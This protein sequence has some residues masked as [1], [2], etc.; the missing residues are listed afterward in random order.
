MDC[1]S[2][3]TLS[4]FFLVTEV[5]GTLN[6]G[7]ND[8]LLGLAPTQ[9]K[10]FKSYLDILKDQG[11]IAR[12]SFSYTYDK[13]LP[14]LVLGEFDD[15]SRSVSFEKLPTREGDLIY[16]AKILSY[17]FDGVEIDFGS[18]SYLTFEPSISY[19]LFLIRDQAVFN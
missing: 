1:V 17:E 9:K 7:N 14:K 16:G 18:N 12:K 3:T 15:E 13:D 6:I 10:G 5:N 2:N 8:G 4:P 19:N 11:R